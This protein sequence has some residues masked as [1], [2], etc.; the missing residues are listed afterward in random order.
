MATLACRTVPA[1]AT[2]S[3]GVG[4]DSSSHNLKLFWDGQK[5]AQTIPSLLPKTGQRFQWSSRMRPRGG[6][7]TEVNGRDA[8]ASIP[9][10]ILVELAG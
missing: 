7:T 6:P 4:N 5:M 10:Q 2:P 8:W 9:R 1:A 3:D